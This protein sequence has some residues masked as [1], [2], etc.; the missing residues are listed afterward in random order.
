MNPSYQKILQ[1]WQSFNI[2][3][4]AQLDARLNSF[5][6]LFAYNSGK[7]ENPETT[8]YDTRE[9]FENGKIAG[10]S[11]D[12]ITAVE[13][14][15]QK[16]VYSFLLPKIIKKEPITMELVK[17]VHGL[18]T[19][20]TYDDRRF[21]E[22]GERPG[23]FK[24]TD[25]VVG[26]NEIG[27]MPG[28]VPEDIEELLDEISHIKPKDA[29]KSAAYFHGRFEN[30]HPF[31]DGNGRTGRTMLNYF[32]LIHNHPPLIIYEEDRMKYYTALEAFDTDE[33]LNPMI[34][35][36]HNQLEKTWEKTLSRQ[37]G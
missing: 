27:S 8:Y 5:R 15:N 7:I 13:I 6:V 12:P 29:F 11:G 9:V 25:F 33:N 16:R 19:M 2:T 21:F 3:T 1:L 34:E 26:K 36:F 30:I 14:I 37:G 31:A 32:L 22:L 17:T 4:T 10:F 23:E 18:L 35:F 28:D 24:K 20:A